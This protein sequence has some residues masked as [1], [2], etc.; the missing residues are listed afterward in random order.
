L[1]RDHVRR[2]IS[3]AACTWTVL[4]GAPHLW[5]ALGIPFGF[6]GGEASYRFFMGSEWRYI[7][8]L[9]VVAMSVLGVGITLTLLR[10]PQQVVRRWIPHSLAWFACGI[11]TLRGV[12]GIIVDRMGDLIW[13]PTFLLGGVLFGGVAWLSRVPRHA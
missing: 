7:Y 13:D 11:L 4:F 2:W 10:P 6:P 12:A 9:G 8:D 1:K 5:W 3:Y